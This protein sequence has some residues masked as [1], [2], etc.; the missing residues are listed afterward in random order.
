[1]TTQ[2]NEEID[3]FPMNTIDLIRVLGIL[4]DNAID[5]SAATNEKNLIISII[6]DSEG[7]YIQIKNSSCHIDNIENLYQIGV[8]SKGSKRG[9][10]LYEARKILE[11]YSNTLLQTEY[12]NF[13]FNQK[14]VLLFGK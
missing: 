8:S 14:L 3:D 4:L 1:M 7:I 2:V 9:L 10:G 13:V 5:S 11:Q 12:A 6:K